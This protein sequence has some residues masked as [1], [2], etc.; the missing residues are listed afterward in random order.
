MQ[1]LPLPRKPIFLNMSEGV[2]HRTVF[3]ILHERIL[4]S[5]FHLCSSQ[6]CEV[7]GAHLEQN[8]DVTY[9]SG[10]RVI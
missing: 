8:S 4:Y 10:F 2:P 1:T 7:V 6:L 9:Q 3:V 5:Y